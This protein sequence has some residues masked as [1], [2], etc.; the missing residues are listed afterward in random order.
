MF[1]NLDAPSEKP[2][3]RCK[4][5]GKEPSVSDTGNAWW[6]RYCRSCCARRRERSAN[7]KLQPKCLRCN[8]KAPLNSKICRGCQGAEE[9]RKQQFVRDAERYRIYYETGEVIL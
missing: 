6:Q 3:R 1:E 8:N 2:M 4:S 7:S 5:C 9:T